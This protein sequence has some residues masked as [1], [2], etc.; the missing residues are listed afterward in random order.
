M[1]KSDLVYKWQT[2]EPS[3]SDN[4]LWTILVQAARLKD[5]EILGWGWV[6]MHA[7]DSPTTTVCFHY[8]AATELLRTLYST[9]AALED[10]KDYL[11]QIGLGWTLQGG[12][13]P[14]SGIVGSAKDYGSVQV[15]VDW[16]GEI[17]YST[18][19]LYPSEGSS[20]RVTLGIESVAHIIQITTEVFH[21]LEWP[22]PP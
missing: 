17:R 22:V 5:E 14:S 1:S 9:F 3:L 15:C 16:S 12:H 21:A 13:S 8:E 10:P 6:P 2:E 7:P 20:I 18:F 19:M 11:N 4:G